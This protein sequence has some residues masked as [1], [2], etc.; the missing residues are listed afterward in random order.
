M[1]IVEKVKNKGYPMSAAVS[2]RRDL[3]V[4]QVWV[5]AP[6]LGGAQP[7]RGS[8]RVPQGMSWD[9]ARTSSSCSCP[10]HPDPYMKHGSFLSVQKS[11]HRG[12]S[13]YDPDYQG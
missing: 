6:H 5:L 3:Q 11:P 13:E 4:R 7:C 1:L 9:S 8:C 12:C 2:T 10:H